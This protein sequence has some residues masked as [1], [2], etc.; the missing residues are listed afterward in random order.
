MMA[1]RPWPGSCLDDNDGATE[2]GKKRLEMVAVDEDG[3]D[4]A[5]VIQ[6]CTSYFL[7]FLLI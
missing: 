2:S 6:Q 7:P 3:I 1:P 5:I 4:E